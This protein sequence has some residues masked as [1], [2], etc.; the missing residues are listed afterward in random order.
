MPAQDQGTATALVIGASGAIGNALVTRF[1][2][3]G[4]YRV[5]AVSRQPATVE[6][7]RLSWYQTDHSDASMAD[8]V[9]QLA[10]TGCELQR[11]AICTGVL[12]GDTFGPEKKVEQLTT[13][14]LE[15]VFAVNAFL[16]IRWLR[17]LTSLL[18][19]SPAVVSVLSARVGSI[20]DN[21]SGGWYSYRSS[22][23]AL[24]MM[25]QSLS[26]EYARRA[27]GVKLIAFHPGTTDSA[28]SQPFQRGVPEGKLFE[29]DFVAQQLTTLMDNAVVDGSLSFLD[30][31]GEPIP[32]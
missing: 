15:T 23:A 1:L 13:A 9:A 25:L 30:W 18:S 10:S 32:W 6:D 7:A 12:H 11:V 26:V 4:E 28:L 16:P 20:G 14:A 19:R 5:V 17:A 3:D 22:K 31:R 2:N 8:L 24:N 27:R 29:P 21:R